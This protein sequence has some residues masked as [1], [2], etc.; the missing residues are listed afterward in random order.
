MIT[1]TSAPWSRSRRTRMH[2][3]YAAIPPVT[4]RSTRR[5]L[6]TLGAVDANVRTPITGRGG[7]HVGELLDAGRVRSLGLDLALGDLHERD[8]Q[9]LARQARP[10]QAVEPARVP[11][12][13]LGV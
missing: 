10:D 1:R 12:G 2:A 9:R 13:Q 3:L 5:P 4:P 11:D 8:R 6:R 7:G